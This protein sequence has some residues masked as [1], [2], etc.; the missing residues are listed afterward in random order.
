[1]AT[2][3]F[4]QEDIAEH[5]VFNELDRHG[6]LL[7]L[8]RLK[9]EKNAEYKQR[10]LDVFV[11]KANSSYMGLIH[12]M[13]RELGLKIR[14]EF[15]IT[16]VD[17]AT[18][19][20]AAI[21]FKDTRCCIYQD[22]YNSPTLEIDRWSLDG[23]G[24]TLLELKEKIAG[25][26]LFAVADTQDIDLSQRSMTIFD[27]SSVKQVAR[28]NLSGKSNIINLNNSGLF[29]DKEYVFS[30]TL[31]KKLPSDNTDALKANEYRIDYS[32]GKI[33]CGKAPESGSG[34][35]YEYRDDIFKVSSSTVIIAN[36]QEQEFKKFMFRQIA[37]SD[38]S[39]VNGHPTEFGTDI[40][41]ELISLYPTT[42][43]A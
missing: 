4:T 8:P 9:G 3:Q 25:T 2:I 18:N 16:P 43:K 17:T 26:G 22:Y 42:Y 13:T 5:S 35:R 24:Y 36:L 19:P 40:I 11:H 37:Q 29:R 7:N 10:L 20:Y 12:G 39:H 27:Q 15:V 32:S 31:K 14:Q 30:T 6:L 38:G 1:M 23:G 34:I 28:E 21:V 33:E 41:N